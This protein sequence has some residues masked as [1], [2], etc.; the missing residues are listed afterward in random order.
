MDKVK[1][2]GKLVGFRLADEHYGADVAYVD[3]IIRLQ[4]VAAMP[5]APSFVEGATNLR[6]TVLPVVDLRRR[7]GLPAREA[8]KDSRIV[9]VQV[10]GNMVGMVVDAVL[11]VRSVPEE[12]IE[13]LTKA[14]SL[15]S[16]SAEII[17][18]LS[19]IYLTVGKTEQAMEL[20]DDMEQMGV[21]NAE[22]LNRTADILLSQDNPADALRMLNRS[23]ELCPDQEILHPMIEVVRHKIAENNCEL[24]K[25]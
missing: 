22:I 19:E 8:S 4:T 25:Q 12:A 6:G 11:E 18:N 17:W 15:K 14:R 9:V 24:E 7:L 10:D 16:D 23:L 2:L 21:L 1:R 3:S 20:F 5:H 13:H